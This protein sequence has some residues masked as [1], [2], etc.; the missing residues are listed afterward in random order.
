[1]PN[2]SRIKVSMCT[3]M[4]FS[5]CW[6]RPWTW[7]WPP[8]RPSC[9]IGRAMSWIPMPKNDQKRKT[10]ISRCPKVHRCEASGLVI[11]LSMRPKSQA[12]A[13][14]V[15]VTLRASARPGS[16]LTDSAGRRQVSLTPTPVIVCMNRRGNHI[17]HLALTI[18][19]LC[20][21]RAISSTDSLVP[22][23][24][25]HKVWLPQTSLQ[26]GAV[27]RLLWATNAKLKISLWWRSVGLEVGD[28]VTAI[29][30]FFL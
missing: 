4:P 6:A 14:L 25:R 2:T 5:K 23:I 8:L 11:T 12:A 22:K 16:F 3:T 10:K 15:V 30:F 18:S 26:L 19:L 17:D 9:T 13:R 1:M 20:Y 28:E 7:T 21:Q 24:G 27:I 29:L